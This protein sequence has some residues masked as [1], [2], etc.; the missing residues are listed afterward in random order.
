MSEMVRMRVR[1]GVMVRVRVRVGV[2]VGVRVRVRV[3]VR[4]QVYTLGV[5]LV[6]GAAVLH[7]V[8]VTLRHVSQSYQRGPI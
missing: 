2:R 7:K 5:E 8:I 3:R 6:E 4:V 1:V